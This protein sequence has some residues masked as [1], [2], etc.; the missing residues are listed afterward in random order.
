MTQEHWLRSI[1][2]C[3]QNYVQSRREISLFSFNLSEVLLSFE[4]RG[5]E[6][7]Q[8]ADENAFVIWRKH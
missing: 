4:D 2:M 8:V 5:R 3:V 6:L 7:S 1:F